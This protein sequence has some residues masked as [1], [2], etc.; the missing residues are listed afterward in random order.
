MST[1]NLTNLSPSV[2][3]TEFDFLHHGSHSACLHDQEIP[4]FDL[5]SPLKIR[6]LILPNRVAMSPMC[7]YSAENGM[8]NDWHFVHLGSR[9]VGGAGLIMVEATSVTD[10]GR[11]TPGDL[12]LW[13]D[14]QIEP[15]TRIVRFVRQQGAVVGIQL[16]HAGRKASCNV[17]WLGGAPLTPEQG[18]WNTIAP[19]SIGFDKNH[20]VPTS[21]DERG[22]EEVLNAF[23]QSAKRAV[24]AGFQLIE[25]HA[26]HGYLLHSFLSPISNQRTDI[27]GG[28]LENRM[29]LL[30]E[31][32]RRIRDILPQDM[33]LFVRISATDWVEGG[34]DIE[35]SVILSGELKELGVDL[36][37]V[38]TGGLVPH[39]KIPV[40]K[41]YQVPFAAKIKQEAQINTGAVGLI[42]DAEY[43]NQIITRGC[44]DLVLIGRELLRDPYWSIHAQYSLDET[45]KWPTAYGYAVKRK[46]HK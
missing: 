22:I 1:E 26:A 7:Q 4:E 10:V 24:K 36:I 29:R 37:D 27:Y 31:V 9:A 3:Q 33:P 6:D 41:G 42:T 13:D 16:A 20:P 30:L 23:V 39:A 35:Q 17:P 34:W 2:A 38:S 14:T 19:S 46:K 12:G 15:L 11:I 43:A 5:F 32:T 18:A 28:S 45:P 44:A 21:L 8:A 40:E 25:I